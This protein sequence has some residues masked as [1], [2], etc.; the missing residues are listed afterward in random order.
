MDESGR[1]TSP[2]DRDLREAYLAG[3]LSVGKAGES[4]AHL[5]GLRAVLSLRSAN[6]PHGEVLPHG[7]NPDPNVMQVADNT[8]TAAIVAPSATMPIKVTQAMVDA[9]NAQDGWS[10]FTVK[11]VQGIV[12]AIHATDSPVSK[13][14]Q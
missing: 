2:A 10:G 6:V 12:D 7:W 8:A 11:D 3:V 13:E 14:A 4:A 5:A 9:V 1:T